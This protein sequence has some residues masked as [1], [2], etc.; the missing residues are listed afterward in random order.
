MWG[1]PYIQLQYTSEDFLS[2]SQPLLLLNLQVTATPPHSKCL[3]CLS[4]HILPLRILQYAGTGNA[5]KLQ[6]AVLRKNS[7]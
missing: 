4:N 2:P 3:A 7:W 6:P 5:C 1:G